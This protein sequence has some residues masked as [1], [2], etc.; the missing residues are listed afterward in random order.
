MVEKRGGGGV[1][2][3]VAMGINEGKTKLGEVNAMAFTVVGYV[4]WCGERFVGN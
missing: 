1:L 2:I 4:C 3:E